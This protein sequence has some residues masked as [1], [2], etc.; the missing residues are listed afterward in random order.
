M[1][2]WSGGAMS[3]L[4]GI[5][6]VVFWLALLALIVWLVR[7]LLPDISVKT[8]HTASES[9][10]EGGNSQPPQAPKSTTLP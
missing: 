2:G 5:G 7:R 3:P 4:A 1:M 8:T 9:E 10:L 6:I